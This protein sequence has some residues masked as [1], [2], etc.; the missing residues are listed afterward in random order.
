MTCPKAFKV[1]RGKNYTKYFD[2][3]Y[4]AETGQYTFFSGRP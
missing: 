4:I 3:K 2:K 1:L